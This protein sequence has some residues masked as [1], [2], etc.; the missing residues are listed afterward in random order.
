MPQFGASL[1]VDA[2]VIIYDRNMFIIQ[3]SNCRPLPLQRNFGKPHVNTL[4]YSGM[5]T[6]FVSGKHVGQCFIFVSGPS[7]S[8]AP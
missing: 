2:R 8:T 7:L 1:N 4:A 3:A 6:L 5:T